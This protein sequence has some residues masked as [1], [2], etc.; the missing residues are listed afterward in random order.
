M[1][2]TTWTKEGTKG[3]SDTTYSA[4]DILLKSDDPDIILDINTA[5]SS[6]RAELRFSEEGTQ[7]GYIGYH[8]GDNVLKITTTDSGQNESIAI[9]P[10]GTGGV[11]IGTDTPLNSVQIAVTNAD[12]NDGLLFARDDEAT[13]TGE[14]LGG[15]G[16]DSIDGNAPSA[17]GEASCSIEAFASEDHSETAKGGYLTFNTSP[18]GKADDTANTERMRIRESGNIGIGITAPTAS[19]HI[20]QSSAS[21]A[22]PVLTLDQGD[23]SEEMIEF[24]CTI[25]TGNAIEAVGAKS[26][27][28]THFIKVTIQGG[29]T[30]YLPVGTIA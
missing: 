19:L 5:S 17:I 26:L 3:S 25:G 28:T 20:D 7:K 18:D 8:K 16:F 23:V 2:G 4:S 27:T 24:L 15:I 14:T 11:G 12:G 9:I 30:R 29:L 1:P 6:S 13:Q 10:E 22:K 21:G